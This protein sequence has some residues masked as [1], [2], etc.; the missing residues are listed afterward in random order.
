MKVLT[1]DKIVESVRFPLSEALTFAIL[2]WTLWGLAEAFYWQKLSPLVSGINEQVDPHIYIASFLLYLL[3]AAVLSIVTYSIVK[4]VMVVL[5]RFESYYFRAI[6]LSLILLTFFALILTNYLPEVLATTTL[7][8]G[9]KYGVTAAAVILAL[10]LTGLLFRWAS[11]VDFRIRR[12]G[13]IMLSVLVVSL[14][15]SFVR[16][17]LFSEKTKTPSAPLSFGLS[18]IKGVRKLAAYNC[19]STYFPSLRTQHE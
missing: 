11:G 7:S 5:D 10:L 13:T 1:R 2:L 17:P 16:F 12:T 8:L 6:T 3:I 19:L 15:L 18:G 9:V 4:L 14:L